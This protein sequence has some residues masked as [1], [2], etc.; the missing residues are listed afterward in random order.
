VAFIIA[1][2]VAPAGDCSIAMTRD[3]FEAGADFLVLR[4]LACCEGFAAGAGI[5]DDAESG[6]FVDCDIEILRSVQG[7]VAPHH[8]SPASAM[9]PAGQDPGASQRPGTDQSTALFEEECQ[10]FLDNFIARFGQVSASDDP[11]PTAVE[12]NNVPISFKK[13]AVVTADRC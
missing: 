11:R 6:F 4:S 10:S 12:V 9:E 7:G 5:V 3:C 1:A 13:S 8:R 2:I